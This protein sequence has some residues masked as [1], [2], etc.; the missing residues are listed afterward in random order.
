MRSGLRR[1]HGR[2]AAAELRQARSGTVDDAVAQYDVRSWSHAL[3]RRTQCSPSLLELPQVPK[4]MS[5][6]RIACLCFVRPK[7]QK[8]SPRENTTMNKV[9]GFMLMSLGAQRTCTTG[10]PG[11]CQAWPALPRQSAPATALQRQQCLGDRSSGAHCAPPWAT[12][13]A[14]CAG[15]GPQGYDP[16]RSKKHRLVPL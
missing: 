13:A 2:G 12:A 4:M 14:K 6:L 10:G 1:G 7:K 15:G 8:N 9:K 5:E 3:A 16:M 11:T